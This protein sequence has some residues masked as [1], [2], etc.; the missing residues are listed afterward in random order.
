MLYLTLIGDRTDYAPPAK[1]LEQAKGIRT[2]SGLEEVD[3]N[4]RTTKGP[5]TLKNGAT[6]QGQWMNGLRDGYG[7]QMW[8]DGSKYEG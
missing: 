4:G 2:S 1:R 3:E 7:V 8:P 5:V 6:Y